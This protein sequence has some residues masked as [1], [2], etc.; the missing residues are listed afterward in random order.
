MRM[1]KLL[2]LATAT[3]AV[4]IVPVLA[5]TT[6]GKP[7]VTGMDNAVKNINAATAK[8]VDIL[9]GLLAKV[10]AQ[11]QPAIQ[12]AID[13][14]HHGHDT[15]IAAITG[16]AGSGDQDSADATSTDDTGTDATEPADDA[17]KPGVTGLERARA[18]VTA[19]FENS[20]TTLQ[21]L[22][23]KVPAQAASRIQAAL[24]R[25]DTTRTVA[26][27]NLDSLIAGQRP[28]HQVAQDHAGRP[29]TPNRPD[30]PD[31]PERPQVPVRPERPQV[32][33]HPTPHG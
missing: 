2:I 28:E 22:L 15:A 12:K 32:P 3:V 1:G 11:A 18:A 6:S 21:G 24:S 9:T 27:N 20:T 26:L 19:G 33:D 25:L 8:Q 5:D 16:H 30:R 7:S 29:E 31:R 17:G 10:P 4:A 14:A 23:D 13:A